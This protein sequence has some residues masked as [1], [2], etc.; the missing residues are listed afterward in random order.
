MTATR[1]TQVASIADWHEAPN[2]L[3]GSVSA[4]LTAEA[5]GIDYWITAAAQGTWRG[6]VNGHQPETKTPPHML[7]DGPLRDAVI[8]E[9]A[10]RTVAEDKATRAIAQL[11]AKAPDRPLME[12]YSTQ[13]ID[14]ARHSGAFRAHLGEL[15]IAEADIDG[16]IDRVAGSLIAAVLDPL[17]KFGLDV[18][19]REHGFYLGALVLTVL[20]EGV[21]APAAELSE[22]KWKILDPVAAEIERGANIDEIRHL[23]VGSSVVRRFLQE[24]PEARTA[25]YEVLG[26]GAQLWASLPMTEVLMRRETMF[27]AGIEQHAD[28]IGDYE[29]WPGRRLLDTTP[30]ERLHTAEKWS[31]ETRNAHLVYMTL[32]EPPA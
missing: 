8:E 17:E 24:Q 31:E 6:L 10:F 28:L 20:V 19:E 3:E 4:E 30:E 13:L 23:S 5:C 7:A 27:Q 11:V 29:I 2:V 25:V 9:F 16:E 26:A 1:P 15:G 18:V 12:F 14:E 32:I 21:L 22:R